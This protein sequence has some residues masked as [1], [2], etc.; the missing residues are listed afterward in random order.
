MT[1][2]GG[3]EEFTKRPLH[4]KERE[5]G[6]MKLITA[7]FD[8]EMFVGA[9]PQGDDRAVHLR[10]AVLSRILMTCALKRG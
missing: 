5:R 10:R 9:V 6:T 3:R 2:T 1:K 4:N 7:L 8:G